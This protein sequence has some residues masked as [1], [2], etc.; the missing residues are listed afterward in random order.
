MKAEALGVWACL[1]VLVSPVLFLP[2]AMAQSP[3]EQATFCTHGD[4][5]PCPEVGI[6]TGRTKMCV[7]GKWSDQCVGGTPPAPQEICDN[8]LDDNCNGAVDECV[9]LSGSIGIFMIIGG[10][11]MLGFAIALSRVMK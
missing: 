2:Q 5:R 4:T 6:C 10:V 3:L 1:L 8:E 7:D 11:L 9:S